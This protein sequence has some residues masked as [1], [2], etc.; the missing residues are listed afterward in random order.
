[1]NFNSFLQKA[2]EVVGDALEEQ[3]QQQQQQSSSSPPAAEE[4]SSSRATPQHDQLDDGANI[5]LSTCDGN[6]KSLFIGINYFKSRSELR[7]CINDVHNIQ[8]FV[9]KH[10]NFPTDTEH[11][12]VLV[13]DD[14]SNMPTKANIIAGFKWLVQ[15]AKAGDS[16]FLHYSGH[17][18]SQKD[19]DPDTDEVDGCDETLI[20]VDYETNGVIVDDDIHAMLVAGL[21][22]GVRLTAIMDCCHSGSVFDLPYTYAPDGNLEI[23][24]VD[25][26]KAAMDAAMAAGMSLMKGDKAGA[27]VKGIE[28]LSLYYI[29]SNTQNN[30]EAAKRQIKI[31]SAVADVIQFSGC[32]DE[33]TSADANIGGEST[34][35]MSWS[36]REAFAEHGFDQTYTEL[37]GNIRKLLHG[38]YTQVPQMS[39]GHRMDMKTTFQM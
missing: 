15:G 1:M 13:D 35:A 33:Q 18:G 27:L 16:L 25:N 38:K 17:G 7:G 29:P 6:K 8:D 23:H 34:G 28:A 3:Q 12:R 10:W 4:S 26:R 36:F 21:P 31:R 5:P 19:V 37:L 9:V 39:T 30:Q 2:V 14:P 22:Q 11:M 24:E 32:R 20:P